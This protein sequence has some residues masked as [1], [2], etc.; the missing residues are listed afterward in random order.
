MAEDRHLAQ[1]I[2][3]ARTVDVRKA[4]S[5]FSGV[6]KITLHYERGRIRLVEMEDKVILGNDPD[7]ISGQEEYFGKCV[8]FMRQAHERNVSAQSYG[9]ATVTIMY[10]SGR[11]VG[12]ELADKLTDKAA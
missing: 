8:E 6:V 7:G 1:A 2:A 11:I 3:F 4:N 9:T 5:T 12:A 10:K